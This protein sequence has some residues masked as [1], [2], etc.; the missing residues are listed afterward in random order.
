MWVCFHMGSLD[1]PW[2]ELKKDDDIGKHGFIA[3]PQSSSERGN[4]DKVVYVIRFDP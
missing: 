4:S 3:K 2:R 1:H